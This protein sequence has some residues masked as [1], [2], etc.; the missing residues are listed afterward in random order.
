[1]CVEDIESN[2]KHLLWHSSGFFTLTAE[3]PNF[4]MGDCSLHASVSEAMCVS[5]QDIES[6][7]APVTTQLMPFHTDC[8]KSQFTPQFS[9]M[10]T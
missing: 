10:V 7:Q 2:I 9:P 1:M 5:V 4:H 6:V 8:R 3:N